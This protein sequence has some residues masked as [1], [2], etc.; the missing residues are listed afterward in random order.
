MAEKFPGLPSG[1]SRAVRCSYSL[2]LRDFRS[3]HSHLFDR[4]ALFSGAVLLWS[5]LRFGS[6]GVSTSMIAVMFLSIWGAVHGRG[7]FIGPGPFD[8]VLSLQL[9]LFFTATP[10]MVLAALVEERKLADVDLRESEERLRL[11]VQAGRAYA[12]NWDIT[13]DVIPLSGN[14]RTFSIGWMIPRGIRA[15]NWLPG[16]TQT[17]GGCMP[18]P[19]P[20]SFLAWIIRDFAGGKRKGALKD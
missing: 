19:I 3:C 14:V 13:T 6:I 16:F 10:F 20:L 17:I 8:Q 18:L 12:F 5:A 4:V 15:G 7:P 11:A 1:S 9:L 2:R